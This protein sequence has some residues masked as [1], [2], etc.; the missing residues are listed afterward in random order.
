MH[1]I[2][3]SHYMV[4][5]YANGRRGSQ[6]PPFLRASVLVSQWGVINCAIVCPNQ[7]YFQLIR[8][9]TPIYVLFS[10]GMSECN[11]VRYS[12]AHHHSLT[13]DKVI[14]SWLSSAAIVLL[15]GGKGRVVTMPAMGRILSRRRQAVLVVLSSGW[16]Q[17]TLPL[18]VVL[19]F[20]D[21][22]TP[23]INL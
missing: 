14:N 11:R 6:R 20:R 17:H 8:I 3:Q 16:D 4:H 5:T 13:R 2:M 23:L 12:S 1:T 18:V 9:I 15:A 21:H 7:V 10:C 22:L 19:S